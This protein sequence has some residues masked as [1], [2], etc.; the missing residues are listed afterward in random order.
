MFTLMGVLPIN[1]F[2]GNQKD[3]LNSG[4]DL[5]LLL[6]SFLFYNEDL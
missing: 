6:F 4:S 3:L 5:L 1:S 2:A